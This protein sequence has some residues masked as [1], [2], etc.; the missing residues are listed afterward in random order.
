M[1]AVNNVL[2]SYTKLCCVKFKWANQSC[3][4]SKISQSM[5]NGA[6][7]TEMLSNSFSESKKRRIFVVW[8]SVESS[9]QKK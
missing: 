6:L 3:S 4:P 9:N 1:K 7:V 2:I 5:S 8:E